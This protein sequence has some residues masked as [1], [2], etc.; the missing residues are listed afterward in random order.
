MMLIR[1]ETRYRNRGFEIFEMQKLSYSKRP[2]RESGLIALEFGLTLLVFLP[3]LFA[4]GEF[5]RLSLCDQ[6]LARGVH[7]AARAAGSDPENCAQAARAAFED[8]L[9]AGWIF[10]RD[11][12]GSIGFVSGAGPDGSS[13]Q[14]VR[15]DISSDDG[16]LSNGVDFAGSACGDSGSWIRIEAVVSVR[17]RFAFRD[18][19]R[20]RVSWALNQT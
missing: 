19:L 15:I 17:A 18:I 8:D 13:A 6:A 2:T 1:K 3:L 14:E 10:D 9:L 7:L 11:D 12:D 16:D 5:Y 4:V 20:K